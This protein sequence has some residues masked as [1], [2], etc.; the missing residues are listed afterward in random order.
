MGAIGRSKAGERGNKGE[1]GEG[2]GQSAQLDGPDQ[3]GIRARRRRPWLAIAASL[4]GVLLVIA[5]ISSRIDFTRVEGERGE[6]A[7]VSSQRLLA[8][9]SVVGFAADHETHAWLGIPYARPPVGDLRWR[10]PQPT[11]AWA[12]TLDALAFGS[13]CVQLSSDLG[14]VAEVDAEGFVGSEDCLY[15]NVWSPRRE[16]DV[17]ASEDPRWPVMVWI[18]G[19]DNRTGHGGSP[20]FDGAHLAGSENVVVVSFN[21]RLG[22][23]GWF[24]HPALRGTAA[25]SAEA[26]GN[27]G[28]LD[29][30][31]ALEWVR[32]NIEEFGGDPDNVTIFGE[33]DGATDVLALMLVDAAKGLFHRAIAQSASTETVSRA[34]AE[35]AITAAEPGLPHGSAEIAATL[36]EQAGV[37][38]DRDA[39]RRYAVELPAK[40][41]VAFLRERSAGEVVDAY[42]SA[43]QPD[44]LD[45]PRLIRDGVVL[46]DGDW[47]EA[48]HAGRF[49]PVP[50][51]LGSNRDEMKL[52]FSDDESQVRRISSLVYSIR[53]PEDYERRSRHH[54]DLWTV[55][56]VVG[57][58]AAITAS[59]F[60]DVYAYRF[61]W[62]ELPKRVGTDF[63]V[64]FGAAHGFE[65]PFVFGNFDLGDSRLAPLFAEEKTQ[66]TRDG[67]SARMMGYWAEFA[68]H[69]KP[70]RGGDETGI[71]WVR[72]QEEGR[73]AGEFLIFDSEAGGG[74]RLATTNL[75]RDF[76]IAAVA[77]EPGLAQD[78]KCQLF[79]DLFRDR[80]GWSSEDVQ[81]FG[82]QGCAEFQLQPVIR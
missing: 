53:D 44:R 63:A 64:L 39:A 35:N 1:Q 78:E 34:E 21:Y 38:P 81:R 24:S 30:I 51:I 14:G 25:D 54:S 15:L 33:S 42:R 80:P 70:G 6:V 68:R 73:D 19:G 67:L 10:A 18:H 72:W 56:A 26:S 77:S 66:A 46:P 60:P 4:I 65:I 9:G 55:R 59:G 75:S 28:T 37:V 2:G 45:V 62:D 69:G 11:D 17:L 22:P 43:D 57:P 58:A 49:H 5:T 31:R 20:M 29:Q 52:F 36:I 71:E 13:P 3:P 41:L 61:D 79:F 27:F 74:I 12:D 50:I 40:D 47:I 32:A 16:A 82:Q 7:D 76:V 48:F 23:F 8:L